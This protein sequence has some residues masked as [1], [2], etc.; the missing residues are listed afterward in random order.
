MDTI[1]KENLPRKVIKALGEYIL[2][3]NLLYGDK[4]PTEMELARQFGVSRNVIR[5]ALKTLN[6]I[7]MIESKPGIGSVLSSNG[8]EPFFMPFVFG[9]FIRDVHIDHL[10]NLR[11]FIEQGASALAA[12][13][14][15]K[16]EKEKLTRLAIELDE[17]IQKNR[18]DRTVEEEDNIAKKESIFHKYLIEI[19]HNPILSKLS[20]LWDV[21]FTRTK[22]TG[23]LFISGEIGKQ[24]NPVTHKMIA[25]A[26]HKGD[27]EQINQIIK[28]HLRFFLSAKDAVKRENLLVLLDK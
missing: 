22:I 23:D 14:A 25:D 13:H 5:E 12:S 15:S 24:I 26:I 4:L 21:F 16:Q 28:K 9:L 11:L 6:M 1:K 10:S 19:S 20:A 27:E 18:S 8:I 7:G 3:E 17:L 2:T